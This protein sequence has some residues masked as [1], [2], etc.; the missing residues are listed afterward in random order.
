MQDKITITLDRETGKCLVEVEG[1]QTPIFIA[2]AMCEE[3]KRHYET[4]RAI[5]IA[6]AMQQEAQIAAAM[7]GNGRSRLHI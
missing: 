7:G 5:A 6:Q 2:L 1:N 3:A 4:Q